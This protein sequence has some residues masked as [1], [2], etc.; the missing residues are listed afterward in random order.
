MVW[1]A[2]AGSSQFCLAV[3]VGFPPAF[4]LHVLVSYFHREKPEGLFKNIQEG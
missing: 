2:I 3:G 4:K 1:E